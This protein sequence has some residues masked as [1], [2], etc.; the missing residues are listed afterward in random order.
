MSFTGTFTNNGIYRSDPSTQS[1]QNLTLGP[2]GALIGETG[3]VFNV[4]GNLINNSTQNTIWDTHL[5]QVGFNALWRTSTRLDRHGTGA[6]KRGV[7]R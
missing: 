6:R 3:D 1:Y 2:S 4:R 7:R 5:S